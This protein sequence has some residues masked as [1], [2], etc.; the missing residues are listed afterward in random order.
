MHL[1]TKFGDDRTISNETVAIY[2]KT[3]WRRRPSLIFVHYFRFCIFPIKH[4]VRYLCF[5]FHQNRTIFGRVIEKSVFSRWPPPPFCFP[6]FYFRLPQLGV[7]SGLAYTQKISCWSVNR[8]KFYD[9]IRCCPLIMGNPYYSPKNKGFAAKLL[10]YLTFK[11]GWSSV[12]QNPSKE[13]STIKIGKW[14]LVDV[15][16]CE[17]T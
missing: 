14:F 10:F 7:S 4:D 5:K 3:R 12:D 16:F 11:Y 13:P 8:F 17:E 9:A 6:D 15:G 2:V 1:C